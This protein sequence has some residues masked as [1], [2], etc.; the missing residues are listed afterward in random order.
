LA[1]T[2]TPDGLD[3]VNVEGGKRERITSDIRDFAKKYGKS[4]MVV[5]CRTAA[6]E[7]MLEQFTYCELADFTR[8][9]VEAFARRWFQQNEMKRAAFLEAF[10][11]P[12]NERLRELA[13][14]LLLRPCLSA[15]SEASTPPPRVS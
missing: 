13:R 11:H 14:R 3:E 2:A 9:Q 15:L 6:T 1:L 8:K 4:R 10:A 7:Y 12:D 5:T